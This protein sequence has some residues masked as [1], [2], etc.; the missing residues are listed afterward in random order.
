MTGFTSGSDG[1]TFDG[2]DGILIEQGIDAEI[3]RVGTSFRVFHTLMNPEMHPDIKPFKPQEIMTAV[4][5]DGITW[6][7]EG[8]IANVDLV[9]G[10]LGSTVSVLADPTA[11]PRG[12]GSWRIFFG[13]SSEKTDAGEIYSFVW[14]P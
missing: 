3:H 2:N 6:V 10:A 13:T 8:M 14:Y 7:S 11:F 5:D 4:S 12:D 9:S 1:L